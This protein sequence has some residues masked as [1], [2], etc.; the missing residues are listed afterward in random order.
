MIDNLCV[1]P[2]QIQSSTWGRRTC[3]GMC[4]SPPAVPWWQHN[5]GRGRGQILQVPAVPVHRAHHQAAQAPQEI[6]PSRT[7]SVYAALAEAIVSAFHSSGARHQV[8]LCAFLGVLS[9]VCPQHLHTLGRQ[10]P[11]CGRLVMIAYDLFN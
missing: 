2:Q 4:G 9:V 6:P 5:R 8:N 7:A 1:N 3:Q 10:C 11:Y